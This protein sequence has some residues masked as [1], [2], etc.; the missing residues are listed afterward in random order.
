MGYKNFT[1][2]V[3]IAR[4]LSQDLRKA[5][6][7]VMNGAFREYKINFLPHRSGHIVA[8]HKTGTG[9]GN[10]SQGYTFGADIHP[11]HCFRPFL[12]KPADVSSRAAAHIK[13]LLSVQ[14]DIGIK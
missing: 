8:T 2:I 3:Q 12:G 14:M 10:E 5:L 1:L 7:E 9:K 6:R 11:Q 13:D 4:K